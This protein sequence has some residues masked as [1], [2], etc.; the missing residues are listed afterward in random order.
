MCARGL[1]VW[2]WSCVLLQRHTKRILPSHDFYS[3]AA[4][5][6]LPEFSWVMPGRDPRTGGANSD[7]PC[8]DI[9]LGERLLKVRIT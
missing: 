7:H 2:H 8:N 1:T 5:G 6:T 9:A 4:N 3:A